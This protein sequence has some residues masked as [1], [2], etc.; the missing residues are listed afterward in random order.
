MKD[1]WRK[2]KISVALAV[3]ALA[4]VLFAYFLIF[5]LVSKIQTSSDEIQK[6]IID[7]EILKE[8][9]NRIPEMRQIFRKYSDSNL[10]VVLS[11]EEKLDFIKKVEKLADETN[12]KMRIDIEKETDKKLAKSTKKDGEEKGIMESLPSDNYMSINF[13]LRGDYSGL[14]N[15]LHK[16]ENLGYYVNVVALNSK[17]ITI[18]EDSD[19][20]IRDDIFSAV[21]D[22]YGSQ[23]QDTH[24]SAGESLETTIEVA[25]YLK[26]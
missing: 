6:N 19:G 24:S 26:K 15:F 3:Y 2:H 14:I 9:V 23:P 10:E 21:G 4:V 18:N 20:K 16:L 13:I 11:A 5:P 25:V 17:K 7:S 12:N 1:F 8:R 22:V